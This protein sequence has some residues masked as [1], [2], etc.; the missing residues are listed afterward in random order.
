[1]V[2]PGFRFAGGNYEFPLLFRSLAGGERN[3]PSATTDVT[4]ADDKTPLKFWL[5]VVAKDVRPFPTPARPLDLA[6]LKVV[7]P[8]QDDTTGETVQAAQ[9]DLTEKSAGR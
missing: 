9:F 3:L 5:V 4:G 8:V 2:S 6:H 7:A 1:M